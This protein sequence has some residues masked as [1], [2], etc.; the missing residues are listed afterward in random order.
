MFEEK[1]EESLDKTPIEAEFCEIEM[2]VD[3]NKIEQIDRDVTCVLNK[4]RSKAEGE[5]K[6]I[7]GCK[8]KIIIRPS[9]KHWTVMIK[10]KNKGN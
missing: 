5:R 4:T 1:W 7:R 9:V 2:N 3:K 10:N 6:G 8:E